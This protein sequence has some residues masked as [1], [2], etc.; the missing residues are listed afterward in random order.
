MCHQLFFKHRKT[1]GEK[2]PSWEDLAARPN[3]SHTPPLAPS[4]EDQ[5]P[6]PRPLLTDPCGDA[7][8]ER[9]RG[10]AA[11]TPR[12]QRT[13]P[14]AERGSRAPPAPRPSHTERPPPLLPLRH[15]PERPGGRGGE[16]RAARPAP[17]AG[18]AAQS[19]WAQRGGAGRL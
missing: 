16:A 1:K 7:A 11:P 10:A 9:A 2:K 18:D 5:P 19:P 12:S 6:Q 15:P 14:P 13:D 4:R 17:R 3:A 8:A